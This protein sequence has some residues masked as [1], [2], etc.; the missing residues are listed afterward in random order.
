MHDGAPP[1]G[2]SRLANLLGAAALAATGAMTAAA[3]AVT[4]GG[5]STAAALVTLASQPGIGVTELGRRLGLSQPGATR[6]IE[7]M[8]HRGLV[9]SYPEPGGR[10][11]ALRLTDAGGE[12]ARLILAERERALTALLAPLDEPARQR[13]DAALSVMLGQLTEEGA[14]AHRTCRLCDE[15]ACVAAAPCPVDEAWRTGRPC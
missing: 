10:T 1:G 8:A 9:R 4:E 13:L 2:S 14:P 6:L 12:K 5:L 3:A 11:V 15:R 7:T